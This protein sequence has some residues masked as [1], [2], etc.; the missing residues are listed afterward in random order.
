[1][2]ENAVNIHEMNIGI[3]FYTIQCFDA[4]GWAIWSARDL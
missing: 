1:V 4:I 3:N 2:Q